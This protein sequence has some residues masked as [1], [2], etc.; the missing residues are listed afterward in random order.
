MEKIELPIMDYSNVIKPLKSIKDLDKF[1]LDFKQFMC[2]FVGSA[3]PSNKITF[4]NFLR[5][6]QDGNL[7]E[8]A[9]YNEFGDQMSYAFLVRKKG[10]L[11]SYWLFVVQYTG[12]INH[13]ICLM[14][15]EIENIQI[16]KAPPM[17]KLELDNFDKIRWW[18]VIKKIF[19]PL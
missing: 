18:E 12:G 16:K 5:H 6:A 1:D 8:L 10:M 2:F 3:L 14:A 9:K 4:E 19:I 11:N 13:I 15:K 17:P 7:K